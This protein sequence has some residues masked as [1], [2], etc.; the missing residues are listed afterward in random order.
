MSSFARA[1]ASDAPAASER[2][3]H[4]G[5]PGPRAEALRL[6]LHRFAQQILGLAG[7]S[8]LEQDRARVHKPRAARAV[9][10]DV[11][12]GGVELG[13]GDA[14]PQGEEHRLDRVRAGVLRALPG[15]EHDRGG[16][17]RDHE[18]DAGE[19]GHGHA[20]RG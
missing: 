20:G 6:A 13:V 11:R 19:Y 18:R 8:L 3:E 17:R 2:R 16:Y 9:R 14:V 4:G 5:E 12:D 7:M 1:A 10:L 15:D